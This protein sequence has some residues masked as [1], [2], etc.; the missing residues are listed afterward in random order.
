[1]HHARTLLNISYFHSSWNFKLLGT[2]S[3]SLTYTKGNTFRSSVYVIIK[4]DVH[5]IGLHLDV[6]VY[7]ASDLWYLFEKPKRFAESMKRTKSLTT[8]GNGKEN[9]WRCH[10]APSYAFSRILQLLWSSHN[11]EHCKQLQ[12][13]T[14]LN[15]KTKII[16]WDHV[17]DLLYVFC[18]NLV[19]QLKQ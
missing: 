13:E 5:E 8:L 10:K 14:L 16:L 6:L 3:L 19:T 11:R 1:M 7:T 15:V 12:N 18:H 9:A 17:I 2:T 4:Q